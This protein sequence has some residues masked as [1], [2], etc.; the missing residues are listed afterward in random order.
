MSTKTQASPLS[1]SDLIITVAYFSIPIQI[2]FS[3]YK[4]PR[5]VTMPLHLVLLLVLF[6]FFIFLCGAGHLTRHFGMLPMN[7]HEG[8]EP[9]TATTMMNVFVWINDLTA[10]VSAATALYLLPLIPNLL[11]TIDNAIKESH[12]LNQETA[13]SKDKLLSFMAFL[14]HEIRNPLFAITSSVQS[15]KEDYEWTGEP[16]ASMESIHDSALLMLR[17]VNDVLD[18]SKI[19][20]G[21]LTFEERNFNFWRLLRN[22]ETCIRRQIASRHG[23]AVYLDFQVDEDT[24]PRVLYGDSTRMLQIAYNLISNSVNFTSSGTIRFK[25][26]VLKRNAPQEQE[27]RAFENDTSAGKNADTDRLL[28]PE[29]GSSSL[30]QCVMELV[31][32][33]IICQDTGVGIAPDRLSTIFE[34]YNQAK[35]SDY[36]KHGGTGIGLSITSSLL[37]L[38]GGSISVESTVGEGSTFRMVLPMYTPLDGQRVDC[39]A[40]DIEEEESDFRSKDPL[41]TTRRLPDYM[42]D[43][44]LNPH[45]TKEVSNTVPQVVETYDRI[46]STTPTE[47]QGLISTHQR[48]KSIDSTVEVER[49]LAPTLV[50]RMTTKRSVDPMKSLPF[51]VLIVD[52]NLVNRKILERMLKYYMIDSDQATNGL[53]AVEK[54]RAASADN[55]SFGLVLMDLSM[56]VMDGFQAIQTIRHDN[57]VI[58]IVALTANAISQEKERAMKV[59]ATDFLT[60]PI[61]RHDLYAICQRFVGCSTTTDATS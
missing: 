8:S 34:P 54:V 58:P 10:L 32:L 13:A 61:L 56:P 36:R 3:L 37:K 33:Q 41:R 57:N 50:S 55:Q 29:Q 52:D 11:A 35:L 14:C 53:E 40:L 24:V 59:G 48:N 26:D 60:K 12:K 19:D 28:D 22:L 15:L 38:M 25:V 39:E 44:S 47:A 2:L 16:Q 45:H 17:L 18:L 49:L 43:A 23:G 9:P 21:K 7:Y 5:L 46:S 27:A 6:A 42:F 4:F 1:L 51:K 31:H 30:Q 20:S